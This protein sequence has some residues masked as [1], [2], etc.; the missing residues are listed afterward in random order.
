LY[1]EHQDKGEQLSWEPHFATISRAGDLGCT[2]G[3]WAMKASAAAPQP[4]AYG[5]FVSIW[6]R[7]PDSSW[8]VV[9]DLG[10]D[11]AV[12]ASQT[13]PVELVTPEPIQNAESRNGLAQLAA[14]QRLLYD[15]LARTYHDA[16]LRVAHPKIRV[17]RSNH[18]PVIGREQA[19]RLVATEEIRSQRQLTLEDGSRSRDFVYEY[20]VYSTPSPYRVR[21]HY[22]AVWVLDG[23]GNWKLILDAEKDLPNQSKP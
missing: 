15:E 19:N 16:L 8:K 5:E 22:V 1:S 7:Q 17:L 20:G 4:D 21:G 13:G 18:Q 12:S 2:T 23:L 14:T 3:P 6:K 11:H 10:I 9:L